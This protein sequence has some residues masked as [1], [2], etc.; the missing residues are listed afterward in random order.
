MSFDLTS[1]LLI[2]FAF[3]VVLFLA[4]IEEALHA[5]FMEG[6]RWLHA[7]MAVLFFLG[8]VF[9]IAYPGQTFGT[10]AVLIAWF[11]LIKGT[12]FVCVSLASHG[13]PLW[14]MGLIVGGLDIIIGLWAIGYPGRSA[15]LLVLWAGIGA[16]MRGIG[17]IVM[18]FQVRHLN[19]E[20]AA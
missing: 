2:S 15:V 7:G 1:V 10:L 14:W 19:K 5:A 9:A 20:Y 17:D 12:A 6:W 13:T 4:G 11:L 18:G 3:S 8:G 16:I